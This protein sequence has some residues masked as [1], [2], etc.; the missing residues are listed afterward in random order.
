MPAVEGLAIA[1]SHVSSSV[2]R[3][4]CE[5]NAS[6]V[7]EKI[8][9]YERMQKWPEGLIAVNLHPEGTPSLLEETSESCQRFHSSTAAEVVMSPSSADTN[10]FVLSTSCSGFAT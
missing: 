1:E 8:I 7:V 5:V 10:G 2:K 6:S 3:A 4:C 9:A